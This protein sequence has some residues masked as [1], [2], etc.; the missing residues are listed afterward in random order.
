MSKLLLELWK[1]K[2]AW[3]QLDEDERT[4]YIDSIGPTIAGL[5]EDGAERSSDAVCL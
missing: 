1:P 3:R 5:I 2:A 4:S